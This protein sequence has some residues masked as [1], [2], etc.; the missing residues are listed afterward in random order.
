M[1]SRGTHTP[2]LPV[3]LKIIQ[4]LPTVPW[5]DESPGQ[6]AHVDRG[7]QREFTADTFP[8]PHT[9]LPAGWQEEIH[10][11]GYPYYRNT[12]KNAT[13]N[14]DL[15]K[16]LKDP[17]D[18][19]PGLG[20]SGE[21]WEMNVGPHGITWVDHERQAVSAPNAS[22][23]EFIEFMGKEGTTAELRRHSQYWAYVQWYPNHIELPAKVWHDVHQTL[24]WCYGDRVLFKK[25]N[26]TF[27]LDDAKEL[28]TILEKLQ[29][30]SPTQTWFLASV[31][32]AIAVD[33]QGTHYGRSNAQE[34]R[35]RESED[36]LAFHE[37]MSLAM[38]ILY[39]IGGVLFLGIPH[40]YFRRIQA[41]DRTRF[42]DGI[43]T[44]RW[45]GFLTSL[46]QEWRDSNL[47]ATVLISAT[48]AFLAVP[49]IDDASRI[50]GLLSVLLSIGSVL[51][52]VFFVWHHQPQAETSGDMGLRYFTHA[53]HFT[54]SS[55]PLSLLLSTPVVLLI[56]SFVGFIAAILVFAFQGMQLTLSGAV[57]PFS[58]GMRPTIALFFVLA[59]AISIA[60][61]AFLWGTWSCGQRSFSMNSFST[62]I[63]SA[64]SSSESVDQEMHGV[65]DSP[66]GQSPEHILPLYASPPATGLAPGVISL[67]SSTDAKPAPNATGSPCSNGHNGTVVDG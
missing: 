10:M 64:T 43:N 38:A 17:L 28:L 13:T 6:T 7:P 20:V 30:P 63:L 2:S 31:M 35:L 11:N 33:R 47:L 26:A 12:Q 42:N 1:T 48:V 56:W 46:L 27:S 54:D 45:R 36:A 25:T 4:T 55:V 41:V 18:Y 60:A 9:Q 52:G 65:P 15:R 40:S 21:H 24:L 39:Y 32:R 23:A 22:P 19:F 62:G 8:L 14:I 16:Y 50:L 58:K 59:L 44:I 5:E 67:P 51:V 53:K 29:N 3:D 37:E 34:Y 49:G 61:W 57:M 66:E